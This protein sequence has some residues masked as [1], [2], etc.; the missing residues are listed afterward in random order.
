MHLALGLQA[1]PMPNFL[2][3]ARIGPTDFPHSADLPPR[4]RFP[5]SAAAPGNLRD[6]SA[7]GRRARLAC[8]GVAAAGAFPRK[9]GEAAATAPGERREPAILRFRIFRVTYFTD[10]RASIW[11]GFGRERGLL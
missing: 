1:D 11:H 8:G 5:N 2:P 3:G 4:L 6:P 9:L 7:H 10:F